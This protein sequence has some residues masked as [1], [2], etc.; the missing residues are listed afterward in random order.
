[1]PHYRRWRQP[2]GWYFF[3][4]VTF[5]RRPLFSRPD[6]R[7]ALRAAWRRV[8]TH[9]PFETFA[10]VLLPDH[11]HCVWHLPEG[12]DDYPTR[13][14]L[15]KTRTTRALGRVSA[16]AGSSRAR[17][18]EGTVWQRRYWEHVLR[19]ETDLKR[20]VDYIHYNPVKHGLVRRA[21][22]WPHSTFRK[23]VAAGEYDEDWGEA[24]PETLAGWSG[25]HE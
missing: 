5:D 10:V 20:H 16:P 7:A 2:G 13:W 3:T 23:F 19:D 14:R 1:M 9:R 25:A 24:E 8:Q 15:I 6:V 17:R 22:D 21:G 4:V 11:L 12:D 18:H